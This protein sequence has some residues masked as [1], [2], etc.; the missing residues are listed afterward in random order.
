MNKSSSLSVTEL[1]SSMNVCLHIAQYDCFDEEIFDL[2]WNLSVDGSFR[3]ANLTPFIDKDGIMQVGGRLDRGP[4]PYDT[5]HPVILGVHSL[6]NTIV[7][8]FHDCHSSTERTFGLLRSYFWILK[9]RKT[10]GTVVKACNKCK[11]RTAQ[12]K[13]PF[14]APLPPNRLTRHHPFVIN[15]VDFFGPSYVAVGRRTE[16]RWGVINCCAVTRAID[17]DYTHSMTADSYILSHRRF[18]AA[19]GK[20]KEIYADNG[21]NLKRL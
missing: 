16:K 7:R 20:P 14:I 11:L 12:P 3:L 15:M 13:V 10:V 6:T 2:K 18:V 4:L 8:S 5:K 1:A 9:G 21:S 19:R 17:L